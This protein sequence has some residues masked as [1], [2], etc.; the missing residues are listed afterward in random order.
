MNKP[1]HGNDFMVELGTTEFHLTITI[2][3]PQ[4]VVCQSVSNSI[5]ILLLR[6]GNCMI[7]HIIHIIIIDIRLKRI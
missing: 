3:G 5:Y 2:A 1:A 7:H 6:V 4:Y